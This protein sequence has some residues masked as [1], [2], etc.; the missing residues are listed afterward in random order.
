MPRRALR[1]LLPWLLAWA[2]G[3]LLGG[4]WLARLELDR[5]QADFDTDG[6]IAYA[7]I[8]DRDDVLPDFDA[9]R[10]AVGSANR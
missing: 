5:L 10:Q 8:S 7:W 4:A 2:I 1:S 6:R 9:V 3:A